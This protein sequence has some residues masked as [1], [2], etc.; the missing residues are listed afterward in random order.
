MSKRFLASEC[1]CVGHELSRVWQSITG[2]SYMVFA[3]PVYG[4]SGAA[5]YV[6]KYLI[7]GE[8]HRKEL[9]ALGFKRRF[10]ISRKWP[11]GKRLRLYG[12]EIGAWVSTS[13]EYGHKEPDMEAMGHR[14]DSGLLSRVGDP[15]A[16]EL[17]RRSR[18][19]KK[20]K[21]LRGLVGE[22]NA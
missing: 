1:D 13:F 7:K 16:M 6:A 4:S 9:E 14:Q 18:L 17:D 21:T 3:V 12:T 2:D 8:M 20:A 5:N 22:M 19:R 15:V 11:G 10:S